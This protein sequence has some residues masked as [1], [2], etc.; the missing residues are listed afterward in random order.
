[1]ILNSYLYITKQKS[2]CSHI[3][4]K[5]IKNTEAIKT[6]ILKITFVFCPFS[7]ITYSQLS[8]SKVNIQF[9]NSYK[10]CLYFIIK[11]KKSYKWDY[12]IH[13]IFSII[14]THHDNNTVEE[15][16]QENYSGDV[17]MV[18][19]MKG[20]C[21]PSYVI[22]KHVLLSYLWWT[23][24]CMINTENWCH[25]KSQLLITITKFFMNIIMV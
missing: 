7:H 25:L 14:I 11:T 5:E 20:D 24:I 9:Y 2:T 17:S 15:Y 12:Y 13:Y 8:M 1:M 21:N 19:S 23:H 10:N 16:Q 6:I 18:H 22:Y 3:C 4:P